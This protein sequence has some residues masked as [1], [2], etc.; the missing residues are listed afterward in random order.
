MRAADVPEPLVGLIMDGQDAGVE[1]WLIQNE[2]R[3]QPGQIDSIRDA[4]YQRHKEMRATNPK[5]IPGGRFIVATGVASLVA[6]LFGALLVMRKRVLQSSVRGAVANHPEAY[7]QG[8]RCSNLQLAAWTRQRPTTRGR[9]SV[10][11]LH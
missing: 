2:D 7:G 3:L 11:L 10:R 6:A 1:E 8:Q 9:L 4:R 5:T